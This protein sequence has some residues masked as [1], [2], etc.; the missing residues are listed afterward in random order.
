MHICQYNINSSINFIIFALPYNTTQMSPINIDRL[1]YIILFLP[2]IIYFVLIANYAVNIPFMDDYAAVLD[3]LCQFKETSGLEKLTILFVQHGEHRILSSRIIYVLCDMIGGEISFRTLIFIGNAQLLITFIIAIS[4]IRKCFPDNWFI[5]SCIFSICLFDLSNSENAY[6]AMACMQNYGIFFL[7]SASLFFYNKEG[8]YII[9]AILF[10]VICI[11]SS[12]NGIVA[13]LCI[14]IF[15]LLNKNKVKSISSILVSLIF[16]PL[17][18]IHYYT[19]SSALPVTD[20]H[21]IFNYFMRFVSGHFYGQF[22]GIKT[23]I[24]IV[25]LS[26]LIILLPVKRRLY[27]KRQHVYFIVML[28]F[29]LSSIGLTS[30]FRCRY[31]DIPASRYMIYPHFLT[32]ILF[33][34]IFI[35][36][37]QKKIFTPFMIIVLGIMIINYIPNF[38]DGKKAFIDQHNMLTTTDY[39]YPDKILAKTIS[40]HS[41]KLKIYCIDNHRYYK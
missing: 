2:T 36:L 8:Y 22:W 14:I 18:F 39:T 11:F 17:Y 6:F 1:K 16:S 4:F 10:Q 15:N 24:S 28:L 7:L 41:C 30:I 3:F 31:S 12:G 21:K 32:A 40:E 25:I 37:E 19:P 35:K 38:I 33:I 27:V 9:P 20:I 29:V 26:G 5:P 34:F 23:I 13:S